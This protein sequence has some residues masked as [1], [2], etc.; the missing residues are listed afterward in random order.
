MVAVVQAIAWLVS[1][2][3]LGVMFSL[4]R[5]AFAAGESAGRPHI[6]LPP[7]PPAEQ[8]AAE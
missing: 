3:V 1:F 6:E 5:A 2:V 4:G 8:P 7:A